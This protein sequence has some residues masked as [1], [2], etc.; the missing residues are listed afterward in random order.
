MQRCGANAIAALL[1]A[2]SMSQLSDAK[3]W[4]EVNTTCPALRSCQ[5][6]LVRNGAD[7][8]CHEK[9]CKDQ[10]LTADME[11]LNLTIV[12]TLIISFCDTKV[13]PS[14]WFAN[15]SIFTIYIQ[16][17][18]FN[19]IHPDAFVGMSKLRKLWLERNKFETIPGALRSLHLVKNLHIRGHPIR[20]VTDE[21]HS[22]GNLKELSLRSNL[23]E[24]I[25][26]DAFHNLTE[27]SKLYL[28]DNQIYYLPPRLFEN[29]R[30][31]NVIDL[32]N[33]RIKVIGEVFNSIPDLKVR[34]ISILFT[35]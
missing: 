21:L 17:S 6:K 4:R 26:E 5:C 2:V 31:L 9:A 29:N 3:S 14:S 20:N 10:G 8:A 18:S 11:R 25:Q 13:V 19:E 30:G 34:T 27:L 32:H 35:V 23:I 24:L 16:H 15:H 7:V 12:R 33:N 1:I 22:L 28:Q